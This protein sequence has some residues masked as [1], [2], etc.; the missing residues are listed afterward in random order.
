M[1]SNA[2]RR[3][4]RKAKSIERQ[5]SGPADRKGVMIMVAIAVGMFAML[6]VGLLVR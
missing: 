2:N 3:S 5:K 4:R 6:A 1:A